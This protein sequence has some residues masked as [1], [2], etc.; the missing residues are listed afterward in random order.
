MKYLFLIASMAFAERPELAAVKTVYLL[1]MT[2]SLDQFLA[3][4]LT[5]GGVVQVV[6]DPKA[7]D[8]VLCDAIGKG[9]EDKLSEL[10]GEKKK[11]PGDKQAPSFAGPMTGAGRSKGAVFLIDRRTRGVIWSD[12][13]RPKDAQPP[14]LNRVANKIADSLE[15]EKKGQ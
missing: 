15:K 8:A 9:L 11:D 10:Y 5:R 12:Y 4:R 14:E 7:A 1:P 3:V 13:V 2:N 6:T